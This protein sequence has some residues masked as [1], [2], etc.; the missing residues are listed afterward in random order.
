MDLDK[1]LAIGRTAKIYA[2][3]EG[4]VLKVY[5]DWFGRGDIEY[6]ARLAAAIRASGLPIPAVGEILEVDGRL[7]LEY[8]RV[9]GEEML[10]LLSRRPLGMIHFARRL[11]ELHVELH[12][13]EIDGLPAQR[14]RLERKIRASA[15]LTAAL[16]QAALTALARLPDGSV[17]CHGD[18]HP[19]NVLVTPTGE[20]VIDWI[21]AASGNPLADVARS[22]VIYLGEAARLGRR[23][24][25]L[26]FLNA[27]YLRHYF[28]LRPD[29]REEFRAWLPIIA[30]ARTSENI[31]PI[32]AW[33]V[34]KA[35]VLLKR[36]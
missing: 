19:K 10:D 13:I 24:L 14:E 22:S 31:E 28:E 8:E 33:L 36:N 30:A 17:L 12:A 4:W 27:I 18:F 1:P 32:N 6:E 2:W 23:G 15:H 16:K 25:L 7:G 5:E 21:D 20:I 29:A 11:A 34:K 3:K 35:S 26:R 9:D